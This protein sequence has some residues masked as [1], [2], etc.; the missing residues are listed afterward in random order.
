MERNLD[1]RV[2]AVFPV[3][4]RQWAE[5]LRDEILPAYFR[6]STNAWELGQDGVYRR[7]EPKLGETHFDVQ[8]WLMN[9]Y[10][11]PADWALTS[12]VARGAQQVPLPSPVYE[13]ENVSHSV[14]RS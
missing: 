13:I 1:R 4:D 8:A 11:L 6:D 14:S 3:E 2:E 12:M 7:I 10:Q 9:R 5:E